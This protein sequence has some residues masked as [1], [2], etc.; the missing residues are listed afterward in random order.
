MSNTSLQPKF[1]SPPARRF[2][3]RVHDY[4]RFAHHPPCSCFDS[5]V[6]RIGTWVLC[7]GCSC[8]A[9]GAI[10]A[11][12]LLCVFALSANF[13][14]FL[15][16]ITWTL[17]MGVLCYL[18]TLLQPFLQWK[19][20]K[21]ISRTMLGSAIVVIWYGIFWLVPWTLVGGFWK[22]GMG[23]AFYVTVRLSLSFRQR[24]TP[25]PIR[26][27]GEGCYPFCEGNRVRLDCALEELKLAV[28]DPSDPLLG[29][30]EE[31]ASGGAGNIEVIAHADL[32]AARKHWM[33]GS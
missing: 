33:P 27:C 8:L 32:V 23:L 31:L 5:H 13:P 12:T 15:K 18:P 22:A 10:L 11:C 25:D 30:A 2:F 26:S 3:E 28:E 20:F 9:I 19:P 1:D 21:I 16:D 4:P 14:L 6:L 24:F 7:L 29:F 17:G